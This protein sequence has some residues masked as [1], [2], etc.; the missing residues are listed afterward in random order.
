MSQRDWFS[1]YFQEQQ[2][3]QHPP[4][5][6]W[7]SC[8]FPANWNRPL[9]SCLLRCTPAAL[10]SFIQI[11]IKTS[12]YLHTCMQS[13]DYMNEIKRHDQTELPRTPAC[14]VLSA[15]KHRCY[16]VVNPGTKLPSGI[17]ETNRV[18]NII[19]NIPEFLIKYFLFSI[20]PV[21]TKGDNLPSGFKL[22]TKPELK[23]IQLFKFWK[24]GF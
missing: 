10:Q 8:Q 5:R 18:V 21:N 6:R 12:S 14:K 23:G 24:K 2:Y 11:F 15:I 17:W 19:S 7:V 13:L 20:Q 9:S 4:L 16:S 3:F 1:F 22:F